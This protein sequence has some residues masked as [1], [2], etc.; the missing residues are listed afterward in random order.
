MGVNA[1][2][3][4]GDRADHHYARKTYAQWLARALL[5]HLSKPR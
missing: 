2:W 5:P 4:R 3:Q 1:A